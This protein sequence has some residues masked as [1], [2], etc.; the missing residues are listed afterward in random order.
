M[1]LILEALKKSEQQRRLGEAPTL[2]SPVL[3]SRRRRNLLP[4]LGVAIVAALGAGW[5]LSRGPAVPE[6]PPPAPAAPA[7]PAPAAAANDR[8][9]APVR[10]AAVNRD[11]PVPR[12]DP[13]APTVHPATTPAA[14]DRPGSVTLTPQPGVA[15]PSARPAPGAPASAAPAPAAPGAKAPGAAPAPA[16]GR[17]APTPAPAATT[18]PPAAAPNAAANPAV[19]PAAAAPARPQAP[20]QPA[21]PSIWELPY[22]TRKDLPPISLTMHVYASA[23]ADR[24]IVIKGERHVEGDDLGDGLKLREIRPEGIVLDFKGQRF[25]FPRDGR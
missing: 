6:A 8:A 20:P 3:A 5:W 2:G 19:P 23:P 21:L 16:T 24:F 14:G 9:K 1:S 17:P 7:R 25:V 15:A 4:L 12:R 11:Q 10:P 13:A 22:S 18:P